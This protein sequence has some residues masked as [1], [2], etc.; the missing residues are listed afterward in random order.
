M[1]NDV[2]PLTD[3]PVI[4]FIRSGVL[5]SDRSMSESITVVGISSFKSLC[6]TTASTERI[7]GTHRVRLI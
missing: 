7:D 4:K 6:Y 2:H 1:S 3:L 5:T